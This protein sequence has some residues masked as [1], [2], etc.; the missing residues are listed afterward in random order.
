MGYICKNTNLTT[1][2]HWCP[3]KFYISEFFG[4][5]GECGS[6]L[7][8]RRLHGLMQGVAK[9]IFYGIVVVKTQNFASLRSRAGKKTDV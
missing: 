8:S 3:F 6:E 7:I 9:L 1:K 4:G 5:G 2:C